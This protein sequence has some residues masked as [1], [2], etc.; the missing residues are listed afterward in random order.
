[1]TPK[2]GRNQGILMLAA[3]IGCLLLQGVTS[4]AD[5][6]DVYYWK[7]KNGVFHFTNTPRSDTMPFIIDKEPLSHLGDDQVSDR[8][9]NK[10]DYDA[11]IGKLAKKFKVEKA[12]VKAVIR[13]ESGFN[14]MAVSPAGACGLMQLM[15]G[16][17][18]KHGVRNI[19]DA[20]QNIEGGVRHLK[21]LL[22]RH[23]NNLPRVLAA[24]NAGSYL[25]DR[26]KGIP[27]I[28][29]TQ[30]YVARVLRYRQ[31]YLKQERTPAV[32]KNS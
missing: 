18:R 13:A 26:Y 12:L 19:Y 14:R 7:D 27:P 23:Q 11:L 24:Y 29:E 2:N 30:D 15:P 17:A 22:S 6:A 5:A 20:E 16:T 1:M 3:G 4:S 10:G 9:P 31:Q 8:V 28:T 21:L 25:V 32:A